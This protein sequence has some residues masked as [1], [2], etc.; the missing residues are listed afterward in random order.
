MITVIGSMNMDLMV[1]ADKIPVNGE[2]NF[3]TGF[4]SS[5]GGKGAN[6]AV[7]ASRLGED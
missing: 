5:P 4:Q 2:T 3:G 6:Q 7:A 1:A